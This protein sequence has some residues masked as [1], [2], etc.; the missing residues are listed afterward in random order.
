MHVVARRARKTR[1]WNGLWEH[2]GSP[3]GTPNFTW[4]HQENNAEMDARF[5]GVITL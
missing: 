5:S 4:P 3:S 2:P 1:V